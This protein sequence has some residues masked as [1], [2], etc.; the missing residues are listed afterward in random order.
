MTRLRVIA[1]AVATLLLAGCGGER[2]DSAPHSFVGKTDELVLYVTWN[3]DG[4]ELTGSLT[5][6]QLEDGERVQTSRASLTGT[7]SGSGVTLD[8][9]Q[10]SGPTS[11]TGKLDGDALA[12]EY[13]RAG[14]GL[15]TVRLAEGGAGVFNTELAALND[16]VEQSKADALSEAGEA[17][18]KQR[19]AQH[20]QAVQDDIDALK[21]AVAAAQSA[22]GPNRKAN[23]AKLRRDLQMVRDHT[24]AALRADSLRACSSA[25]TVQ[26]DLTRLEGDVA[27]LRSKQTTRDVGVGSVGETIDKLREDFLTLQADE[28]RYLP[29]E[30]PTQRTVGRAIQQARRKLRKAGSSSGDTSKAV[31]AILEQARG[32]NGRT[33]AR[34]RTAGP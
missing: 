7:I 10:P 32:L 1:C 19:V 31:D 20:A 8:L 33:S 23:L 17:S 12:L 28:P 3:R 4:D 13:L 34:C 21:T 22:K 24:Q 6:G 5:Q 18:E 16:R 26:S 14:E 9:K 30:A 2:S 25:A 15:V 11:L 27:A 29:P